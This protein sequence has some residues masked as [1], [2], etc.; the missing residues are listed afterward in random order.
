LFVFAFKEIWDLNKHRGTIE[1]IGNE[2][3]KIDDLNQKYMANYYNYL[4]Q[5]IN[6]LDHM[7]IDKYVEFINTKTNYPDIRLGNVDL[8]FDTNKSKT[9]RSRTGVSVLHNTRKNL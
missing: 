9:I 5:N 2:L 1:T 6:N 8:V 3:N 4:R 7:L